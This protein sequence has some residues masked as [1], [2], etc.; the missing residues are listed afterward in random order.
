MDS[1]E[2]EKTEDMFEDLERIENYTSFPMPERI[3]MLKDK[4]IVHKKQIKIK[5]IKDTV[6]KFIGGRNES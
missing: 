2:I 3:K 4:E 6:I 1:L 5:E